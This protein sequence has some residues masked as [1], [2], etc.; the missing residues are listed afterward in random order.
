MLAYHVEWNMRQLLSPILFEDD[1]KE[2]AE[3]ARRSIVAPAERSDS[4]KAKLLEKRTSD[5]FP[6]HSFQTLLADLA[7]LTKNYIRAKIENSPTFIQ[8][9][10]PTRLQERAFQILG[11]VPHKV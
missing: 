7:T 4:A 11:V 9:T 3:R 5:D 2:G 10:K 1:D 6:V 8:Y